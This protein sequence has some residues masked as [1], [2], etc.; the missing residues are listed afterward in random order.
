M[1]GYGL[2]T[3]NPFG[4]SYFTDDSKRSGSHLL[5]AGE[6]QTFRYRVLVHDGAL[7]KNAIEAA[8]SDFGR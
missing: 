1:R 7:Q 3:A 2:F 6:R 4:I 5:K 8:C